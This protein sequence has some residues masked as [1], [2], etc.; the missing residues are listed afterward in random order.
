ML[1][2]LQFLVQDYA[3]HSSPYPVVIS[4]ENH[5]NKAHQAKMAKIF[6]AIFDEMLPKE[7]LVEL[8]GRER[9]P[10][11][12]ELR[13]KIILKSPVKEEDV[14]LYPTRSPVVIASIINVIFHVL[15]M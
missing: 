15:Y 10:S 9:L 8:E 14:S 3:F 11:P 5:C 2:F 6:R 13:E 12:E 4:I 1:S 7:D